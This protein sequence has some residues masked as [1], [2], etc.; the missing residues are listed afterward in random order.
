MEVYGAVGA[1]YSAQAAPDIFEIFITESGGWW[2]SRS[3]MIA[4]R[5]VQGLF[6]RQICSLIDARDMSDEEREPESCITSLN[7]VL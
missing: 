6:R 3:A 7:F 5:Q 1:G 4:S 2:S